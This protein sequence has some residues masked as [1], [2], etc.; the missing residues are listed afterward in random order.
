M[1]GPQMVNIGVNPTNAAQYSNLEPR[2][3]GLV[4]GCGSEGTPEGGPK[5][6]GWCLADLSFARA[7]HARPPALPACPP[8]RLRPQSPQ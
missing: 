1:F 6:T 3:C 2:W 8:R 4:G 5:L 7:D